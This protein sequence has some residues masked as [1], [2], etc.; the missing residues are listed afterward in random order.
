[1][2][3]STK[4]F[5]LVEALLFTTPTIALWEWKVA[6]PRSIYIPTIII[7][8]QGAIGTLTEWQN[9]YS[10]REIMVLGMGLEMGYWHIQTS[11]PGQRPY[12]GRRKGEVCFNIFFF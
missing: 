11:F 1:M 4:A 3:E 2:K 5:G 12:Y 10:R 8:E 9:L 6:P 7:G